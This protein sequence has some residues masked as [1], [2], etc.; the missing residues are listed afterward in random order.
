MRCL[1]R[2]CYLIVT[3]LLLTACGEQ[4]IR[5]DKPQYQDLLQA[6]NAYQLQNYTSAAEAYRQLYNAYQ[7][8][9]YAI[10]AADSYLQIGDYLQAQQ[11]L[12]KV[13]RS[14]H[15]LFFLV[16]AEL[17]IKQSNYN[18]LL[19]EV[20]G[21]FRPR[22]LTLQAQISQFNQ[23]YIEAAL[24]LIELS[25]LD[26]F[27]DTTN[28]IVN[29][30]LS[31]SEQSITQALFNRAITER[32]QGWLE[33]ASIAKS[34]D[35]ESN[36]DWKDRWGDHP[37]NA[38]FLL[39]RS[40]QN[41]AVLL[42]LTGKYKDISHSIQQG[43]IAALYQTDAKQQKLSFFDTG[44]SGEN[45]L[46]AW[47]G[48]IESGAEFIIGPL[49]KRSI[50]KLTQVS[51]STVPILL[52]NQLEE[53]SNPLGFYQFPLSPEDEI[54][55][56]VSRL[57]AE[58]KKR[59]LLLAPETQTGR[60]L[61]MAFE[62]GFNSQGGE[63]ISY[64]F[65]PES[66]HDYS[67]EIKETLGLNESVVR[68]RNLQTIISSKLVSDSRIRPDVDA[69]FI[70]AKPNQARLL[71]PQLKFF[72][73]ENIP[74]YSTS[75]IL[76]QTVDTALD[77]D[78]N[79]IKFC[80]SAFIIEPMTLQN[81]LNFDVSKIRGLK[82]YFALGFDAI[83]IYPRLEWMQTMQNQQLEGMSGL[84]NIDGNG[85]IHRELA[86]AQFKRGKPVLLAPLKPVSDENFTDD[87]T[88]N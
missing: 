73:A 47:Y 59:V 29:N 37:A 49:E 75:Q 38:F 57:I 86:W 46:S 3:I 54:V 81:V 34:Q 64:A 88:I 84:L 42:P 11:M 16:H 63:L 18:I 51:S 12:A 21:E 71:K 79:G 6:Q 61:A 83:S 41:I 70:I 36:Q 85:K 8:D 80:Q 67:R 45:F 44:S 72:K 23:N 26:E 74:V 35:L 77:R 76:S 55:N 4:T 60:R 28:A 65:Y 15:P 10:Y 5:Q 56:V 30:L 7:K 68:T 69:I 20:V 82:K 31:A 27:S 17:N 22:Y 58:D 87:T 43:M 66:T 9:E 32:Q 25:S 40:Y 48:A 2:N 1:V 24:L 52:L 33:A 78:L 13:Q 53:D 62:S 14:K 19:N 39:M 50:N